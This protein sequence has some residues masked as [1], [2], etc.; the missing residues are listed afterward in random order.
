MKTK[1]LWLICVVLLSVSILFSCGGDITDGEG[2]EDAG[3]QT[4][5]EDI[6]STE[7]PDTDTP[8]TETPGTDTPGTDTPGETPTPEVDYTGAV[9]SPEGGTTIIYSHSDKTS[10]GNIPTLR[11]A[12]MN[13]S[14]GYVGF[15]LDSS[16]LS[17]REIVLGDTAREISK[18]ARARMERMLVSAIRSSA[19]EDDASED[20]VAYTVYASGGSVAIVWSRD[21]MADAAIEYFLEKFVIDKSLILRDGYSHTEIISKS[22]FDTAREEEIYEKAWAALEA[23]V[24]DEYSEYRDDVVAALKQL[25]TLYTDDMYAWLANLYDPGIGGFYSTN[26]GR[27]TVGFLPDIENTS[28]G[29]S[30]ITSTK[31]YTGGSYANV[32]PEK[33]KKEIGDFVKSLQAPDGY[34]YH[35]QWNSDITTARKSRDLTSAQA[36]LRNL[37]VTPTYPYPGT[38]SVS[39]TSFRT[40]SL[41]NGSIPSLVAAVII[42]GAPE[43]F[44][45]VENYK[46][47]LKN[48]EDS[49]ARGE[50]DFYNFGNEVQSQVSQIKSYGKLLG[51]DLLTMTVDFFTE[52]QNQ[53]TGLWSNKYNYNATNGFHKVSS[54]YNSAGIAIPNAEL[55]VESAMKIIGDSSLKIS[56]GVEIYNAWSC[57]DYVIDNIRDYGEGTKEERDKRIAAILD[58]VYP[59]AA[60]AI[61]ASYEMILPARHEDGSFS[62]SVSGY[63]SGA[64]QGSPTGVPNTY[65][66]DVNGNALNC[67]SLLYCIYGALDL[68]SYV[69]PIFTEVDLEKYISILAGLGPVE[70]DPLKTESRL[71]D[72][73]ESV[74]ED[75][76]PPEL[77]PSDGSGGGKLSVGTDEESGNKYLKFEAVDLTGTSLSNPNF[78]IASELLSSAP[79]K[80]RFEM[81]VLFED[82]KGLELLLYGNKGIIMQLSI[83]PKDGIITVKN[84]SDKENTLLQVSASSVLELRC[85]YVWFADETGYLAVY[86]GD[87]ELPSGITTVAYQTDTKKG[88]HQ[89][90]T[91]IHIGAAR[92][93]SGTTRFDNLRLESV[94]V[95]ERELEMPEIKEND[96]IVYDFEDLGSYLIPVGLNNGRRD[97]SSGLPRGTATVVGDEDKYVELVGQPAVDTPAE[98]PNFA[99]A[100]VKVSANN[101]SKKANMSLIEMDLNFLTQSAGYFNAVVYIYSVKGFLTQLNFKV[102]GGA[103]TMT[104]A[105]DSS[106]VLANVQQG[107][108][109]KLRVEYSPELEYFAVYLN[110]ASEPSGVTTVLHED[111]RGHGL[112][113]YIQIG[114]SRNNSGTIAVDNIIVENYYNSELD[115]SI[116]ETPPPSSVVYDFENYDVGETNLFPLKYAVGEGELTV[117]EDSTGNRYL[118]YLGRD[119]SDDLANPTITLAPNFIDIDANMAVFEMDFK[120]ESG[121]NTT[122]FYV[123]GTTGGAMLQFNINLRDDEIVVT[124]VHKLSSYNRELYRGPAD[125][126]LRIRCEFY[127]AA[128]YYGVFF[129]GSENGCY[130]D[131]LYDDSKTYKEVRDVLITTGK[132]VVG[133]LY[134][135]NIMLDA[136]RRDDIPP[137]PEESYNI[138]FMV[139]G[140][141][142]ASVFTVYNKEITLPTPPEKDGYRFE[143]WYFDDGSYKK[144]LTA[145]TLI[146][147]PLTANT[148][149]YALFTEIIPEYMVKFILGGESYYSL[150]IPANGVIT[151]PPNPETEGKAFVGW[152]LD[153]GVWERELELSFADSPLTGDVTVYARVQTKYTVSF[154]VDGAEYHSLTTAGGE[155]ITLPKSPEKDGYRFDGWYFDDESFTER[156]S[157]ASFATGYLNSDVTVYAKFTETLDGEETN[158]DAPSVSDVTDGWY[159]F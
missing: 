33:L 107:K 14:G 123:E 5:G 19:N 16:T 72:F 155:S 75:D 124:R 105:G 53:E 21:S 35:P 52:H 103:V 87:D 152:Y 30:F 104:A 131:V 3:E 1:Y 108:E 95:H 42:P 48:A 27:D 29:L 153:D 148:R 101:I 144:P 110:G 22:E 76:I 41:R 43:Q 81:D 126:V 112:V 17:T 13:K 56:G 142:Y 61:Y 132:T 99:Q 44:Q 45:S 121:I 136:Q 138:D 73:E 34:F 70:K 82:G 40:T 78:E 47:Y 122:T 93:Y 96:R 116:P 156:L 137:M 127:W 50:R 143:G 74:A 139:D 159:N 125:E 145:T 141:K 38:S 147:S 68:S 39:G 97:E 92:A 157:T 79:N 23:G 67:T 32:L 120:F 129:N 117:R 85:E 77:V 49:I 36:I 31:M 58:V 119:D 11:S 109:F 151:L 102:E 2:N 25:Y 84:S 65:E 86:N 28:A 106:N 12:I 118:Q 154:T 91:Y 100:N 115:G 135:D 113:R 90:L 80:V 55:A 6:P 26:S 57:I 114:S 20:L 9:Y 59:F 7:T 149:V 60:K 88:R 71:Y 8:S 128:G 51:E 130:A 64:A 158:S 133:T 63:S 66:G 24:A 46:Q 146:T 69:V 4:P 150:T 54:V 89:E 62:Y 37:G 83:I 140:E 98:E 10:E 94:F 18:E 134:L 15:E 111:S